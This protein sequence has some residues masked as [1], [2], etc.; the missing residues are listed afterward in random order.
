MKRRH[1]QVCNHPATKSE[2]N[3]AE[4]NH[5]HITFADESNGVVYVLLWVRGLVVISW[6]TS[7]TVAQFACCCHSIPLPAQAKT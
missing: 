5:V 3:R 1:L 2:D 4:V 7:D 6:V